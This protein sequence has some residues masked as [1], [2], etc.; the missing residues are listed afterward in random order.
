MWTWVGFFFQ[1]VLYVWCVTWLKRKIQIGRR[2]KNYLVS[3]MNFK[4]TNKKINHE[5]TIMNS[6]LSWQIVWINRKKFSLASRGF[7]TVFTCDYLWRKT[8]HVRKNCL[9]F[10]CFWMF[11]T[12][13]T[14]EKIRRKKNHLVS[15]MKE[16]ELKQFSFYVFAVGG[17][18]KF[19]KKS[20]RLSWQI[21]Y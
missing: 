20:F 6:R 7:F 15:H 10:R 2:K 18:K 1:V 17:E 5:K 9:F 12:W 21:F 13:L 19:F 4:K 16:N 8:N 14:G 11:K 3:H